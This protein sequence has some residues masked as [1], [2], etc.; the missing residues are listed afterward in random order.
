MTR[1]KPWTAVSKALTTVTMMLIVTLVLARS[2]A[3]ASQFK[4]L[5]VFTGADGDC[6][7]AG[8]TFDAAGNLY[9]TTFC[10]GGKYSGVVFKLTPNPSGTWTES[11]LH[12]FTNGTDGGNPLAGLTFDA[13]GNLYG[14]T[15]GGG[16]DGFGVV[17]KLTPNPDGTWTES[18]LHTFT[19][20]TDGEYLQ[21][22]VI[23]DSAGN[24][25]GATE[26]GGSYG[27]GVVFKLAPN[28][29]GTWT[30]SVLNSFTGPDGAIP[31]AGLIFDASGNLYGTTPYGGDLS[32]PCNSSSFSGCGV[33]FKLTYNTDGSWTE[34]VLNS[35]TGPDGKEPQSG[36]I[37][38][39]AGNLYGTTT[40]GGGAGFGVVF[41]L[42]PSSSGWSETVL[43]RFGDKP[44]EYPYAGV[45]VDAAGNLYGTTHGDDN[46]G[47]INY[48]SVFKLTPTSSGWS[49]TVL[50]RFGGLPGEYPSAGLIMDATGNLYGTSYSTGAGIVFEITP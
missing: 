50:H 33:V 40:N 41:K 8:L 3:S 4:I 25:Y 44:S 43:H 32:C 27:Y 23:F 17:F 29:D 10:G 49:Y 11:V 36:L 37:F 19:G 35:F 9:G 18:V 42:T 47:N 20:G 2:A 30:E 46:P 48:G 31:F 5:Y 34:S 39:A 45:I 6:P 15:Y 13:A 7:Y 28:T 12:T 38:D 26:G 24:L 21:A 16:S 14:T 1:N 22:G